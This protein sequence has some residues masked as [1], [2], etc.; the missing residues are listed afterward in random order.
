MIVTWPSAA[1]RCIAKDSS[2]ERCLPIHNNDR[3]PSNFSLPHD[4]FPLPNF[5][6]SLTFSS[7]LRRLLKYRPKKMILGRGTR[8]SSASSLATTRRRCARRGFR[9]HTPP[10]KHNPQ[11]PPTNP[12][13]PHPPH[14]PTPPPPQSQAD[15]R[16]GAAFT[17]R[18]SRFGRFH[19]LRQC[20]IG[21]AGFLHTAAALQGGVSSVGGT[22]LRPTGDEPR[23]HQLRRP[24]G[25]PLV[26]RPISRADAIRASAIR[27]SSGRIISVSAPGEDFDAYGSSRR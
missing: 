1:Q 10:P 3:P 11:P 4:P 20:L 18:A 17:G 8:R 25:R 26:A 12:I 13:P 22:S 27:G 19:R 2:L 7:P 24:T 14:T 6:H 16:L 23:P 5:P 9:P 21:L 15:C